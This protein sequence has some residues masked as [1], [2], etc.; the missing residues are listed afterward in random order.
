MRRSRS[1]WKRFLLI[2]LIAL[3][4][5]LHVEATAARMQGRRPAPSRIFRLEQAPGGVG[6]HFLGWFV[7]VPPGAGQAIAEAPSRLR[8][9]AASLWERFSLWEAAGRR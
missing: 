6:V 1:P 8:E 4:A 7:P 2:G 5:L 3:L 9:G